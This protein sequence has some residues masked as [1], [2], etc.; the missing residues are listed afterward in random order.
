MQFLRHFSCT[1]KAASKKRAH[2][3]PFI[4]PNVRSN[5]RP[6]PP[7]QTRSN[8]RVE[9]EINVVRPDW[10]K[11]ISDTSSKPSEGMKEFLERVLSYSSFESLELICENRWELLKREVLRY[12]TIAGPGRVG[13]IDAPASV[14]EM[15]EAGRSNAE[16]DATDLVRV[17]DTFVHLLERAAGENGNETMSQDVDTELIRLIDDFSV[18]LTS[19]DTKDI[20][21]HTLLRV[22]ASEIEKKWKAVDLEVVPPQLVHLLVGR[23]KDFFS[24]SFVKEVA[25]NIAGSEVGAS[26]SEE[27]EL[28]VSAVVDSGTSNEQVEE[29]VRSIPLSTRTYERVL[30]E[31]GPISSIA[32]FADAG[33]TLTNAAT[34]AILRRY[35]SEGNVNGIVRILQYYSSEE[36]Q[37]AWFADDWECALRCLVKVGYREAAVDLLKALI[38]V[39]EGWIAERS[40]G[41]EYA[42]S[43]DCS[44]MLQDAEALA[45]IVCTSGRLIESVPEWNDGHIPLLVTCKDRAEFDEIVS[46]VGGPVSAEDVKVRLLVADKVGTEF[47]EMQSI[48][49][50]AFNKL[51]LSEIDALVLDRETLNVV[52]RIVEKCG[53]VESVEEPWGELLV[54][55]EASDETWQKMIDGAVAEAAAAAAISTTTTATTADTT[56]GLEDARV[57]FRGS[58]DVSAGVKALLAVARLSV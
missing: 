15:I 26:T 54:R 19:G 51:P 43:P 53:K 49:A 36:H 34:R 27:M 28:V 4:R 32:S 17:Y 44:W 5:I 35:A 23:A 38:I 20:F 24:N 25:R 45:G 46:L 47:N 58:K 6:P 29:I 8:K 3:R 31:R 21:L 37:R 39:R 7:P 50:E 52:A 40:G 10:F 42:F 16:N 13:G 1:T 11:F 2:V 18:L 14:V 56:K 22:R 30:L 55:S 33:Y 9:P 12:D 48:L 41:G 57:V